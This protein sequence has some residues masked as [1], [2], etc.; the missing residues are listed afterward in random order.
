[1]QNN[2]FYVL[3]IETSSIFDDKDISKPSAVWLSYGYM[4]K[5]YT[6][7]DTK[8]YFYFRE[9][10]ELRMY[11]QKINSM[12]TSS[13]ICYSHNLAYEFEFLIRNVTRP[14]RVL[15]NKTH[16][17]IEGKLKD[18][19]NIIFRCSYQLTNYP[20]YRLGQ[21]INLPK[22]EDDYSTIF[23]YE[24]V[25]EQ[26]KKY[27]RRDCDIVGEYIKQR[28][29]PEYKTINNIPLTTT[30]IVRHKFKKYYTT[31][32][33]DLMPPENCYKALCSAFMG[34]VTT[35]NPLYTNVNLY[36]VHSYD[37]TSSYP[38]VML[39]EKYSRQIKKSEDLTMHSKTWIALIRFEKIRSKYDYGWLPSSKAV[40]MSVN[41]E[42][43]NGKIIYS[44][45]ISYYITSVDLTSIN[46]IYEYDKMRV[47]EMYEL[48]EPQPLPLCYIDTLKYFAEEKNRLKQELKNKDLDDKT[49][50]EL[51]NDY[52]IS[53]GHFNSI[54]GMSV[55]K[56]MQE[57][58]TIDDN[59][60][61]HTV[62]K[63][64]KQQPN[65]HLKR[66]FLFGIFITAYARYNLLKGII[67]NC[68]DTFVYC[69]TDSIKFI[70]ENKFIDTNEKLE[71]YQNNK[72]I[73]NLGKFDYEGTYEEFKTYGAK[74]YC[75]RKNG[76]YEMVVAGLPKM[77]KVK[78]EKWNIKTIDDFYLGRVF[79]KC[80]LAKKYINGDS[81]LEQDDNENVKITKDEAYDF[82]IE[83]NITTNGGVLLYPV[84]YKL[85]MTDH[86]KNY[87]AEV[88]EL[89]ERFFK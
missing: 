32:E 15:A 24:D 47:I 40:E 20:L 45:Y 41:T 89:R 57:D 4:T 81:I 60:V 54:Y 29:L 73:K 2:F 44:E 58:Y 43:F 14:S 21:I 49:R 25:P 27:C 7:C 22:F 66:N 76:D 70:G 72:A 33:W 86:D 56:L 35:S 6:Y 75:Y 26:K 19:D 9:W 42:L 77:N 17:I 55:Q 74:K 71:E 30:G 87:C 80:K 38:Y 3:D 10:E 18:Y 36:N 51:E 84:D 69:D 67:T 59:F 16:G 64:Y 46:L 8:E 79:P 50:E 34:G 31:E 23:P 82:Y 1:M 62:D 63:E 12:T 61:W 28:F 85:D 52:M 83:H 13:I 53:K 48:D 5:Y 65:K 37:I 88:Q 39:K 11:L 68:P 78:N